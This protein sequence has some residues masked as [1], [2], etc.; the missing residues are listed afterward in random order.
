MLCT[1]DDPVLLASG[2]SAFPPD[3]SL[4]CISIPNSDSDC[5]FPLTFYQVV[6]LELERMADPR[7]GDPLW[8]GCCGVLRQGGGEHRGASTVGRGEERGLKG[9]REGT[10]EADSSLP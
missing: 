4:L 2:E 10:S 5:L 1:S 3:T 8:D 9:G 6:K 7:I